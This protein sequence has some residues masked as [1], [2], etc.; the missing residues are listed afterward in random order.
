MNFSRVSNFSPIAGVKV[1]KL[2]LCILFK[3]DLIVD[4]RVTISTI[5]KHTKLCLT[6]NGKIICY[7]EKSKMYKKVR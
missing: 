1:A 7:T 3:C 5:Q 2:M 6:K 4:K